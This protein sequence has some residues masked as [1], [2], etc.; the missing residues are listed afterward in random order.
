MAPLRLVSL[1]ARAAAR[2]PGLLC[3]SW[4]LNGVFASL[5]TW[6]VAG[7][8]A[9]SLAHRPE[10]AR[11]FLNGFSLDLLA[12]WRA[13]YG[14]PLAVYFRAALGLAMAYGAASVILEAALLPAYLD[15]FERFGHGRLLRRA[16]QALPG[17]AAVVFW[18]LPLWALLW[19]AYGGAKRA[20]HWVAG[21]SQSEVLPTALLAATAAA[22]L[23]AAAILRVLLNLWKCARVETAAGYASVPRGAFAWRMG[24]RARGVAIL[25]GAA[26]G[27]LLLYAAA[28]GATTLFALST[29]HVK[30]AIVL[31]QVVIF[32]AVALRLWLLAACTV[33]WRSRGIEKKES[34]LS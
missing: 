25:A 18:S 12:D 32:A 33:L 4:L 22:A 6:P 24:V 15:P 28:A 7:I 29:S 23:V 13:A 8:F 27:V 1:G 19:L 5:A 26:L 21:Y 16:S 20:V 10:A 11:A 3:V 9:A 14:A 30:L 17:V 2:R 31:Q 34:M